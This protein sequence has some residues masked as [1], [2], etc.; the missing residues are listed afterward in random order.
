MP[1]ADSEQTLPGL[2]TVLWALHTWSVALQTKEDVEWHGGG[3]CVGEGV[4]YESR[5]PVLKE[6][7]LG[8]QHNRTTGMHK[9]GTE[10]SMN[11]WSVF[12]L[13]EKDCISFLF[14]YS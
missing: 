13:V 10:K 11:A 5:I 1:T 6:L 9:Q 14:V 12:G 7:L 4:L 3:G 2:L 8:I